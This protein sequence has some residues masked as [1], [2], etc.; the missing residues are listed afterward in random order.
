MSRSVSDGKEKGKGKEVE[1]GK[2]K[3]HREEPGPKD[4]GL[5]GQ[6]GGLPVP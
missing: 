5:E 2:V 3:K 4:K 1:K 6:V